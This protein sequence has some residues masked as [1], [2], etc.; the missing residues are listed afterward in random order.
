[1]ALIL[2]DHRR[3]FSLSSNKTLLCGSWLYTALLRS[4]ITGEPDCEGFALL[5][6]VMKVLAMERTTHLV[7][8]QKSSALYLCAKH[9][10]WHTPVLWLEQ[11]S[12][13][14]VPSM[15]SA[16]VVGTVCDHTSGFAWSS[17]FTPVYQHNQW[18][19]LSLAKG[20]QFGEQILFYLRHIVY[21]QN[22]YFP[23]IRWSQ[24]HMG[25][26]A[27]SI[28]SLLSP[29]RACLWWT[30]WG[31]FLSGLPFC[32]FAHVSI[33]SSIPV[34]PSSVLALPLG[35]E[36]VNQLLCVLWALIILSPSES[37]RDT[38]ANTHFLA[39]IRHLS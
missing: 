5:F 26:F 38:P 24:L 23:L 7:Q 37:R 4:T 27:F 11:R 33:V 10:D 1:M 35:Q 17:Q 39:N 30:L 29:C 21:H 12:N 8:K 34:F 19:P 15:K 22:E 16:R 2:W 28:K 25:P 18:C 6:D 14:L 20:C 3:V 9:S 32:L 31:P 36:S 13:L